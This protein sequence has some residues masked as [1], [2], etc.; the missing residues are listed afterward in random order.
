[1]KTVSPCFTDKATIHSFYFDST[2][3]EVLV[4]ECPA[5]G[6]EN[7]YQPT[8]KVTQKWV[9]TTV[10]AIARHWVE[11]PAIGDCDYDVFEKAFGWNPSNVKDEDYDRLVSE[12]PADW[13]EVYYK[14]D[15]TQWTVMTMVTNSSIFEDGEGGGTT[16]EQGCRHE[17]EDRILRPGHS[18][19]ANQARATSHGQGLHISILRT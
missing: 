9:K 19:L 2:K 11:S 4:K 3:V 15:R 10:R 16:S 17:L 8:G 1:M 7:D 14:H 13:Q 5:G 18:Y 12:L 6:I